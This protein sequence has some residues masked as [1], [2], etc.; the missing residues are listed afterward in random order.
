[1][2]KTERIAFFTLAS[3]IWVYLGLRS[4]YIPLIHD[5]TVTYYLYMQNGNFIPPWAYWDANNH[6]LNS[7]IGALTHFMFGHSPFVARLGSWLSFLPLVF[8]LYRISSLF[9]DSLTRWAILIPLL[10]TPFF[11]EFFSLTRGY[12]MAMAWFIGTMFFAIQYIKTNAKSSLYWMTVTGILTSLSSL[13]VIVAVLIVYGWIF[14]YTVFT[15]KEPLGK[16]VAR[17]FGVLVLPQLPLVYYVFQLKE[18]GLLYYGGDDVVKFTLQPLARYFLNNRELWWVFAIAFSLVILVHLVNYFKT[19]VTEIFNPI[20]VFPFVLIVSV[21][22]VFAQHFIL[23]VNYPEDRAALYFFPLLIIS[24]ATLPVPKTIRILVVLPLLWF[25]FDLAT[26][27]NI[28]Y[29]KLWPNEHVPFRFWQKVTNLKTDYP[30]SFSAYFL[31]NGVWNYHSLDREYTSSPNFNEY[32]SK[33]ADVLMVDSVRIKKVDLSLYQQM[34]FDFISGQTL[35]KRSPKLLEYSVRDTSFV[36]LPVQNTYTNIWEFNGATWGENA[37]AIY[38][39]FEPEMSSDIVHL[40]FITKLYDTEG[41]EVFSTSYDLSLVSEHWKT[42]S[43]WRVKQFLPPFPKNAGR[44]VSFVYNPKEEQHSFAKI[45]S[46]L[47]IIEEPE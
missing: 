39:D 18:R 10:T 25:P 12:G 41:I 26:S 3:I 30:A 31:R 11:I 1:M 13:S 21:I 45:S 9:K 14:L 27:A 33:W 37:M 22:S 32:P 38:Y 8:F 20:R 43:N 36:A 34:D 4:Y 17:W 2:N 7:A 5:E 40:Y 42:E 28:Q 44:F 15:Q 46:Q 35:L 23:G 16:W 24:L 29:S 47:S 6:L 19:G